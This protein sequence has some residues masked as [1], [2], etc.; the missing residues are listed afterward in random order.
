MARRRGGSLHAWLVDE[1][2]RAME[3]MD[4][5]ALEVSFDL[6]VVTEGAMA[7]YEEIFP[8]SEPLTFSTDGRSWVVDDQYCV[9]PDCTCNDAVLCFFPLPVLPPSGE[10]S[11]QQSLPPST[12]A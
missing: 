1:K 9:Q 8:F 6:S 3:H 2:R 5:D 11:L 12:S 10:Q 4:L 7:T